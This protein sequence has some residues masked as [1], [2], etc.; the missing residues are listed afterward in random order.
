LILVVNTFLTPNRSITYNRSKYGTSDNKIAILKYM[1]CSLAS[2][3]NWSE[4]HIR[5]S[6]DEPYK[7]RCNEKELIQYIK[8]LFSSNV[9]VVVQIPCMDRPSHWHNLWNEHLQHNPDNYIW[10]CCNHDHIF[11]GSD[12]Y[13]VRQGLS[14]LDTYDSSHKSIYLSHLSETF[15]QCVRFGGSNANK[16]YYQHTPPTGKACVDSIQLIT[17]ELFRHWW[18]DSGVTD[19]HIYRSTDQQN[20]PVLLYKNVNCHRIYAPYTEICRHYDGYSHA[21][22]S[23]HTITPL[24]IPPGFFT[25]EI[26]IRYGYDKNYPD[27]VNINP[28]KA[29]FTSETPDG[30]DYKWVLADIPLFWRTRI[31]DVDINSQIDHNTYQTHRDSYQQFMITTQAKKHNPNKDLTPYLP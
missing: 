17:K 21:K 18:F 4:V 3:N 26:K 29:K 20:T 19:K 23:P 8:N 16:H 9:K 7:K 28:M 31:S 1:L 2:I 30:T 13:V 24:I 14:T 25:D 11:I 27:C 5:I 22:I 12:T 6:L 10:F 15:F